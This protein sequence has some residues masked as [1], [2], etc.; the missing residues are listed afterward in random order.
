MNTYVKGNQIV[1]DV[2]KGTLISGQQ[3]R[4]SDWKA[5]LKLKGELSYN[6]K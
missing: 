3:M 1:K 4:V 2:E 6:P 5:V